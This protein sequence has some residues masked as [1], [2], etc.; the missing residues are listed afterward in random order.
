M[1]KGEPMTIPDLICPK[2]K[3]TSLLLG[4]GEEYYKYDYGGV[5]HYYKDVW[6]KCSC[7]GYKQKIVTVLTRTK[8]HW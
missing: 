8:V 6:V 5:Y 3:N 2:C 7:C 1:D 4:I